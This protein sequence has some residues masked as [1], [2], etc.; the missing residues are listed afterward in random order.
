[1][2]RNFFLCAGAV[3]LLG[4]CASDPDVISE[5]LSPAELIQLAQEASDRSRY[6][7]ALE[8]YETLR[9]RYAFNIEVVCTAEYEIAFIHF[10]QKKYTQA[11]AEL[12]ELLARYDGPDRELLPPQFK[13]LSEIVLKRMETFSEDG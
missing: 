10:K 6:K 4:A 8:Y 13:I 9:E 12:N 11:R 1:M 2:I 3:L 7:K 5:N